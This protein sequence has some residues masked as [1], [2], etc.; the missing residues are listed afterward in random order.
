MG[1]MFDG[2][3]KTFEFEPNRLNPKKVV[4]LVNKN[5]ASAAESFCLE[6]KQ[7]PKTILMGTNTKGFA[8]YA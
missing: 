5:T 3:N 4:I 1:K 8:D 7:S 6:A 2:L